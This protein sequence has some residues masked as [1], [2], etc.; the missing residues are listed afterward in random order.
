MKL[1]KLKNL[2]KSVF[3][4]LLFLIFFFCENYVV[5]PFLHPKITRKKNLKTNKKKTSY[6]SVGFAHLILLPSCHSPS[7]SSP[8]VPT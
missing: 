2:L 7:L 8:L 6:S 4:K 5:S 3:L 1:N